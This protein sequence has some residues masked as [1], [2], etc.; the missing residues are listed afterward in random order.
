M[1]ALFSRLKPF[2]ILLMKK[3]LLIVL[4]AISISA[5]KQNSVKSNSENNKIEVVFDQYWEDRMR[6]FP[7]E[8][9]GI[10]DNRYNDLLP[11][12]GTT[13]FRKQTHDF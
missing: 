1:L 2:K 7:L 10:G 3:I 11:N 13:A 4:T 9:T 12:D 8:A 6:L 5:C